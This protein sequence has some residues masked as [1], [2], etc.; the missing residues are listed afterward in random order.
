VLTEHDLLVSSID[1]SPVTDKIV[2]CSHDRNAFV[3]TYDRGTNTWKPSLVILRIDRAALDVKWSPDGLKFATASGAKCVPV[4]HYE[5]KNDWW[6]SKMIKKHRSTVLC[7]A[8]HPNSQLLATG[9]TDF[10]ARIFSAFVSDVDPQQNTGPFTEA[11]PFAETFAEFT[12]SG[13]IHCIAWSSNGSLVFATHD[14]SVHFVKFEDGQSVVQVLRYRDLPLNCI[15]FLSE[16]AVVG[17]GHDMNPLVFACGAGGQWYFMRKLDQKAQETR[18]AAPTTGVQAAR[19]LFQNKT[20]KGQDSKQEGDELWT[21]HE[22]TITCIQRMGRAA[23]PTS[24]R[25]STS[26]LDGRVVVWDL[27]TLSIDMRALGI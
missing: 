26:A 10:R 1:W 25:F 13:W 11:V 5:E 21:K 17:G 7:C 16:K 8:W 22:N 14:S 18:S 3:W 6:V 20:A 9:S 23:D 24:S 12:T 4:C 19:A 2:S 27:P 15:T